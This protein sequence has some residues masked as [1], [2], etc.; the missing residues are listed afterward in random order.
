[1]LLAIVISGFLAAVRAAEI[2]PG[3]VVEHGLKV[4]AKAPEFRLN[5]AD[6]NEVSL[7]NLL[8]NGKVA[9]VFIRSADW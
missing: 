9:L 6:G 4:G 1:L 2:Q 8:A 3:P 7:T 5:S